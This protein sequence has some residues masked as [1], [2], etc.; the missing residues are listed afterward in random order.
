MF[1]RQDAQARA[2]RHRAPAAPCERFKLPLSVIAAGLLAGPAWAADGDASSGAF[3]GLKLGGYVRTWAS[4]NLQD[5][6]ATE[7]LGVK[8][9]DKGKLN[10]LRA[11]LSLVAD[12][13][14]GPVSWHAVARS[15]QEKLTPYQRKMQETAFPKGGPGSDVLDQYRRTELRE[16][17]ADFDIGDRAHVRLGKQQVVWGETDLFHPTDLIHGFDQRWRFFL[18]PEPDEVRKPLILANASIKVPEADGA[19]QIVLRPGLDRKKDI[20]TT[21]PAFGGR[22]GFAPYQSVDFLAGYVTY[23]Y[24]HPA[25]GYKDVTGGVRWTGLAGPVNYAFSALRTFQPLP[26]LNP[27]ANPYRKAPSGV[28]GDLFYPL[29][30]VYSASVSGEV[31]AVDMV[32]ALEVSYQPNVHFNSGTASWAT[33]GPVVRKD[34]INTTLRLDKQLR[35]MDTLGTSGTSFFVVQLFDTWVKNPKK[36][37]VAWFFGYQTPMRSHTTVATAYLT[38]PFLSGR[39]TPSLLVA[40]YLQDK[41]T[42]LI[43]SVAFSVGNNWRFIVEADIFKAKQP[44]GSLNASG[45]ASNPKTTNLGPFDKSDQLLFRATYQF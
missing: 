45:L 10:M 21:I 15:D 4:F 7:P 28:V 27:A 35:L 18:E 26:V 3:G 13:S 38:L 12:L 20:G 19:L 40:R 31:P 22:W 2:D 14:T 39:L 36:D 43:P 9:D 32:S 44:S 23:D 25:G 16:F 8:Y 17:F 30:N 41:D 5:Q 11:S 33:A 34:V 37:D 6:P 1:K 29:M 42:I 24:D